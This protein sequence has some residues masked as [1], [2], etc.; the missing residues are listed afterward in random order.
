MHATSYQS[1]LGSFSLSPES[2]SFASVSDST[3]ESLATLLRAQTVSTVSRPPSTS[4]TSDS[5]FSTDKTE[6]DRLRPQESL[7]LSLKVAD[8]PL[9]NARGSVQHSFSD[10]TFNHTLLSPKGTVIKVHL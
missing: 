1:L 3:D 4:D 9:F 7:L 5:L 2:S 10:V 6:Q 8:C